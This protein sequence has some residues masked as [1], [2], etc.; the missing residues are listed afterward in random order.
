MPRFWTFALAILGLALAGRV[1]ADSVEAF[2][3]GRTVT[4]F[5]GFDPGGGYDAYARIL[6]RH[7]GKHI[8][9]APTLVVKNMPGAG[10][11]KLMNYL[12][13]AAPRDG[14][15]FGTVNRSVPTQPLLAPEG[16]GYDPLRMSWIGST[17][18]EVSICVSRGDSPVKTWQDVLRQELIVGGTG[19]GADSDVYPR[20]LNSTLGSRFRLVTGYPGG[21]DIVLA[22]ER[23]EVAGRCGWS[24]S[25]IMSSRP[26][27]IE[28]GSINIL[29]QLA[30]HKHPA[31]PD[32][33]L[34]LDLAQT[35][36]QRQVLRLFLAAQVVARPYV[37]PPEVPAERLEALRMA[38]LETMRD[39]DFLAETQKAQLEV[40]PVSGEAVERLIAELFDTPPEI[41]AKAAAALKSRD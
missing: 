23:G 13:E 8:P 29:A 21:S 35:E 11:I 24:Y 27:W 32:V 19:P 39:P 5:V 30:L 3:S 26:D 38:F 7:I 28:N 40:N 12:A 36:E 1:H 14:T 33:P 20:I 34:V 18:D 41:V 22:M 4:L 17:T 2:Y 10:S 9:G 16:V 31:L 37:A 15:A 25:S 6:A